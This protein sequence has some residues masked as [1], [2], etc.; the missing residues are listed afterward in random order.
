MGQ[1]IREVWGFGS[2]GKEEESHRDALGVIAGVEGK[3]HANF[4]KASSSQ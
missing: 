4:G 2:Q 1:R 3:I